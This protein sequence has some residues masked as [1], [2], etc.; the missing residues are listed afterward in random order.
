MLMDP[1]V[2]LRFACRRILNASPTRIRPPSMAQT[3]AAMYMNA[4]CSSGS[5]IKSTPS[6]ISKRPRRK[7]FHD[8]RRR[9]PNFCSKAPK[10]MQKPGQDNHDPEDRKHDLFSDILTRDRSTQ[11]GHASKNTDNACEQWQPPSSSSSRT[12]PQAYDPTRQ[13]VHPHKV[14]QDRAGLVLLK[15]EGNPECHRE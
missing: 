3:L 12:K 4:P 6:T 9:S 13:P 15:Y 1:L 10:D 7:L 11:H 14:S 2:L 5:T 8:H